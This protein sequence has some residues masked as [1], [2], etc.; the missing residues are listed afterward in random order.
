MKKKPTT[1]TFLCLIELTSKRLRY[2]YT[3]TGNARKDQYNIM[4]VGDDTDLLSKSSSLISFCF[5]SN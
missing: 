2:N 4:D 1:L 5:G 3:Q